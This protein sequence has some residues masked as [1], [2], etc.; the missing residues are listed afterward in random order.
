[1]I[2]WSNPKE[3]IFIKREKRFFVYMEIDGRE[4][5]CY[6]P[7]TG[8]MTGLLE[9][10]ALCILSTKSTGMMYQWEAIQ[11][12]GVWIG[13]NTQNP[14]K[15]APYAIQYLIQAGK[16]EAHSLQTEVKF[17]HFRVDFKLGNQL[18]E[19]KHSHWV[20]DDC[21]YFPDC[22]TSR[23]ERQLQDMINLQKKDYKCYNLYI[24]QR[25]DCNQLSISP[26]DQKYYDSSIAAQNAGIRSFAFSCK[27]HKNGIS[28]FKSINFT[29]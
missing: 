8:K 18:V 2:E 19:V 22:V 13:T 29:L 4:E 25:Q 26:V 14:N 15:L 24:L 9:P 1:M 16:L 27:I 11:I 7:N 20:V 10:G 21:A 3:G 17:D 6:C 23:G 5:K 28:I 12:D